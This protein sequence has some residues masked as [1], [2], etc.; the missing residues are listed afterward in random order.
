[1]NAFTPGAC[2]PA[3][4]PLIER[5]LRVAATHHQ[6]QSRKGGAVPYITHPVAMALILQRFGF[7]DDELLA[8]ALLHDVVED[9]DCTLDELAAQFPPAVV[10]TVAALSER[11]RDESGAPRPW[12]DRKLEHIEQIRSGPFAA[13]VV[14]LAD[15]LHNLLSIQY[16]L[17]AGEDVWSRFNAPRADVLW[18]HRAM[19][20]AASQDD[21]RLLPLANAGRAV[22]GGLEQNEP[23]RKDWSVRF[24]TMISRC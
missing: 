9:T 22:Q 21:P 18:Y 10:E 20:E 15:K 24:A 4:G 17:A 7:D 2:F 13:R 12:R 14:A 3:Y 11:K 6:Q 16:D 23:A 19:I 1:M 5:A 8:A